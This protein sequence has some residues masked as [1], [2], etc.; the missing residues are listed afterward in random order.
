MINDPIENVQGYVNNSDFS[1]LESS[2]KFIDPNSVS[3]HWKS[4]ISYMSC[5]SLQTDTKIK[6][7]SYPTQNLIVF[8]FYIS[9]EIVRHNNERNS[10]VSNN[11]QNLKKK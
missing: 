8:F 11:T 6:I 9:F 10:Y 1:I 7:S 5:Y 4:V 3:R 2:H